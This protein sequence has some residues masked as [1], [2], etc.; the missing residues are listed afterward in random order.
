MNRTIDNECLCTIKIHPPFS[1]AREHPPFAYQDLY[2]LLPSHQ[3]LLILKI[4]FGIKLLAA[5]RTVPSVKIHFPNFRK[6][7]TG[8]DRMLDTLQWT[9][10]GLCI[11]HILIIFFQSPHDLSGQRKL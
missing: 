8:N 3:D 7:M 5:Q 10:A 1:P 9:K 2:Q 11:I 6:W 4:L